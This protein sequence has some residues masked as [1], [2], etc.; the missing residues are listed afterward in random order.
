MACVS[1][2]AIHGYRRGAAKARHRSVGLSQL[3][4]PRRVLNGNDATK[5][6]AK[7]DQD[8]DISLKLMH[9]YDKDKS[10]HL[11]RSELHQMLHDYAEVC[12]QQDLWPTDDDLD[13]IVFI[14]TE[15][16]G[17]QI[18]LDKVTKATHLWGE[19]VEQRPKVR[20]LLEKYDADGS[21]L[22]DEDELLNMLCELND[23]KPVS[24]E[25]VNWIMRMGDV[26]GE[27]QLDLDE[28]T[29]AV[30]AWYGNITTEPRDHS[31]H[32]GHGPQGQ[33]KPVAGGGKKV[34]N[35]G[36]CEKQKPGSET[37]PVSRSCCVL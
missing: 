24:A 11:E 20:D 1:V 37:N 4:P 2:A 22:I 8:R 35:G 34:N 36:S 30:A 25:T 19:V 9:A 21:S 26:S 3:P 23:D 15:G 29:R 31:R 14:V 32:A 6:Q 10:G 7:A 18:T 5:H 27:G 33:Q 17:G 16:K 13:F 28:L 12:F